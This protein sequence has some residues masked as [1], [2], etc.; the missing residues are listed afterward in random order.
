MSAKTFD[1]EA[2]LPGQQAY[3]EMVSASNVTD[4][5]ARRL[6]IRYRDKQ[7][8]PTA[9]VHTLNSTAVVTRTLVALVENFQKKD[10]TVPIPEPLLP[11]TMGVDSLRR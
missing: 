10:G 8:S 2:W 5:Q 9:L 1:L 4:Y 11:Y 3:R 7:N 6:L